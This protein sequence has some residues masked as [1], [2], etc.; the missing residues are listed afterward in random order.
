MRGKIE[1]IFNICALCVLIGCLLFLFSL[2]I[3][4]VQNSVTGQVCMVIAL[5]PPVLMLPLMGIKG[6][7]VS[8]CDFLT[9]IHRREKIKNAKKESKN[10]RNV[11]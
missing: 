10:H 1:R 9:H 2:V 5:I 7:V 4:W 11:L 6:K 8:S 3:G